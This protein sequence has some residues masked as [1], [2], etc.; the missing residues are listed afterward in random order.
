MLIDTNVFL[1]MMLNQEKA[2]DCKD[3]LKRVSSG[4]REAVV[5]HFSVHAVEAV[6]GGGPG[7]V[8]FLRSLENS[9]GLSL[10]D[11]DLS[12]ETAASLLSET[13]HRDFDDSLQ[14]YLA[15]KLGV[16]CI[17]SFDRHFDGL[18]IPRAEPSELLRS[19]Q[20]RG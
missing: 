10:H 14:Y 2:Q 5:S 6:L 11:T 16:D 19:E 4:E 9:L 15:K 18:D 7:L 12:D 20:R 1:E 3:L 13:L 17:V 8:G